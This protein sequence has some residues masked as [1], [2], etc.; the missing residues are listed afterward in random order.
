M[1]DPTLVTRKD[2]RRQWAYRDKAVYVRIHDAPD[3]PTGDGVD[4]KWH[5]V[6]F[7]KTE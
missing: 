5:L 2:G 4:G 3:K 1:A 7:F 6:P